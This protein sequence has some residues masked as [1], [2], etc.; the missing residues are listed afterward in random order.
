[1]CRIYEPYRS[2]PFRVERRCFMLEAISSST[3]GVGTPSSP[4][5]GRRGLLERRGVNGMRAA[6]VL[7]AVPAQSQFGLQ[8]F[9]QR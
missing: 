5:R 4:E 8:L 9:R 3:S 7:V 1:M 6:I 2:V